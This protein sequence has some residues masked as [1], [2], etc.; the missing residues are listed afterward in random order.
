MAYVAP[1]ISSAGLVTPSFADIQ[2]NLI[3]Q[4]QTIFGTD[5]YLDGDSQDMQFIGALSAAIYDA[6]QLCQLAVNNQ[7][8]QTATGTALDS[9]VK[10][11]GIARLAATY[12]TVSIT[13]VGI[14]GTTIAA[15]VVRDLAGYNWDMSANSVIPSGG[16]LSVTATCE[17]PG[18]IVAD[19]G[20]IQT[21]VT[22]QYGWSSVSNAA[23]AT[24]GIATETDTQLRARQ[25]FSVGLPSQTPLDGTLAALQAIDGVTRVFVDENTT[26]STDT[27][28]VPAHSIGVVVDGG[29]SMAIAEAIAQHKT[30]GCG[31]YGSTSVTLPTTYGVGGTINFTIPAHE[32]IGVNITVV[33][34][35]GYTLA[36]QNQIIANLQAFINA[37]PIGV[38]VQA[39]ALY[40]PIL[41]AML[42]GNPSFTVSALTVN[43]NGGSFGSS[44]AVAWNQVAA[45]GTITITGGL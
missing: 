22:P 10:L 44:A 24:P 28:L 21:I 30:I 36:I 45:A 1:Y 43:K 35:A 41:Q 17:T 14:A 12:S 3:A 7:S 6:M 11:N 19:V 25:S 31:T 9:L 26:A 15:G 20:T 13:C 34:L 32:S 5:I 33:K 29:D 2:S 39:S 16:V 40:L 18:A 4:A 37:L 38:T 42:G 8:P 23:A 27:N